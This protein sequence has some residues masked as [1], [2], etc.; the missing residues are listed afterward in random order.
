[1]TPAVARSA[2][3][4]KYR[5]DRAPAGAFPSRLSIPNRAIPDRLDQQ[6]GSPYVASQARAAETKRYERHGGAK[7]GVCSLKVFDRK[8][9]RLVPA[10][11][12]SEPDV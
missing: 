7:R 8:V 12:E 1:L 4:Q 3:R 10:S 6:H 9:M 11:V 5:R 2:R